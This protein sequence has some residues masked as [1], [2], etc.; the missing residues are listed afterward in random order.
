MLRSD[1]HS[2]SLSVGRHTR[3]KLS[4]IRRAIDDLQEYLRRKIAEVR[5]GD[6]L[7]RQS[8]DLNYRQLALLTHGLKQPGTGYTIQSH[9]RSHSI[10]YQTA[11]TDL[12]GLAERK[13]LDQRKRGRSF[14]FS[15]PS[16]LGDRLQQ[17]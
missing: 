4:V 9:R 15:A 6:A 5:Q 3:S 16:D 7:L 13:L 14:S 12:L 2:R 1:Y 11:R 10:S 8:A 17:Q